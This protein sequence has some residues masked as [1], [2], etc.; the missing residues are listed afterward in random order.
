MKRKLH[1]STLA[2]RTQMERS[3]FREHS[4]PMHLTSSF[5]FPNAEEMRDTFK[6]KG[7]GIIYSRYSNPNTTEFIEKVCQMEGTEAGF[8]TATGMAAVFASIAAFVKAG[9]HILAS[10][11]LFGS[12]YVVLTQ[13]MPKWGVE[14]TFVDPTD[15]D[16]WEAHIR[17]TT[18]MFVIETPS[19][20]GLTL[21]D[22]RRA[23][24]LS[25]RYNLLL[26]VDNCFAT[27]IVQRPAEYG[28]DLITHSGTKWMDGQG[29]ILAGIVLGREEL[30]QEVIFFCRHTGPALSP[31]NAWLLSKS[32]ETLQLRM[33]RHCAN[34][35][36]IARWL[37]Q[38]PSVEKTN[39]PWLESHPQ[40]DLARRQ[41]DYGGGL[42][43]FTVKGGT[44]AAMRVLNN[45]Q[46]LS[47]TSNLG[48][49]RTTV[50]HPQTTTHHK[51]TEEERQRAGIFP[52]SIRMS[53][54]LE[55]ASDIIW[56]L[57]QALRARV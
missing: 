5:V 47:L 21:I 34:A 43:T 50:T 41:M 28:A 26:N 8:A 6:G 56:D 1:P 3:A 24:E 57:E 40:Y 37:E 39:Y 49:S 55:H 22:L 10:E 13:I 19:N 52:G 38:H 46:L 51:L 12:T 2:I 25:R 7:E 30:I 45:L 31:F 4:A 23:G 32:L 53:V 29:R 54:G 35:L 48:D 11:A 44:E 18:K 20:P 9:D 33:E 15:P 27:P 42:V 17:P 16:S 14:A 36:E